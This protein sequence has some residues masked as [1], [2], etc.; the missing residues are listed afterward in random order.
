MKKIG[1]LLYRHHLMMR[2]TGMMGIA[3]VVLTC[4]IAWLVVLSARF[5]N[6]AKFYGEE[7][8]D[9]IGGI[10]DY[11]KYVVAYVA[12]GIGCSEM[13]WKG[14]C[15]SGWARYIMTMP[16]TPLDR[17]AAV[18]L[19]KL[20]RL[21][22]MFGFAYLN[23]FLLSCFS[24]T[25]LGEHFGSNL[26]LM[27]A[28]VLLMYSFQDICVSFARDQKSFQKYFTAYNGILV[29]LMLGFTLY[30]M[31]TM[32]HTVTGLAEDDDLSALINYF[33]PYLDR[34]YALSLPLL[35]AA[36][37]IMFFGIWFGLS[38]RENQ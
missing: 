23:A 26:L 10:S 21:A 4:L 14:D 19:Y 15:E 13:S 28:A 35:I 9:A 38:R 31:F 6:I 18:S 34:M 22:A 8:A 25:S 5:G 24:G 37:A 16:V 1:V 36:A 12:L 32:T 33:Q 29:A 17:S 11:F 3:V 7:A 27:A 30:V 20:I 2:K